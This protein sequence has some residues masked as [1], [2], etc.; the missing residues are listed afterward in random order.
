MRVSGEMKSVLVLE[1]VVV[2]WLL[3]GFVVEVAEVV[4]VEGSLVVVLGFALVVE[5][6]LRRYCCVR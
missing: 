2:R 5:F 6:R 3:M 4:V 1:R